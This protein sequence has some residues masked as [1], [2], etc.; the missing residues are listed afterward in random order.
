MTTKDTNP[1]DGVGSMKV[2]MHLLSPVAKAHWALAQFVGM[3]KYQAWNWRYAGV[4]TS[5]YLAAMER[6]MEAFKG[7]EDYDPVDGTHHLGNVMACAA[8]LL[9]AFA[10]SKVVDDRPP[11]VDFR[12]TWD[13]VEAQMPKIVDRYAHIPQEPYTI[14]NTIVVPVEPL[15]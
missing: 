1:K 13:W 3:R 9:D 7:G 11:R 2:P 6:H 4:K 14:L 10:A 5:V 12:P 8:I 15:E